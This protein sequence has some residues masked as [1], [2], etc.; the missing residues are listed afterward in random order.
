MG[1]SHK[2]ASCGGTG[3]IGAASC[4]ICKGTGSIKT[5]DSAAVDAVMDEL[6]EQGGAARV[7]KSRTLKLSSTGRRSRT[8]LS[9]SRR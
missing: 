5:V 1:I 9:F 2:C 4:E 6:A 7:V 3:M 8:G